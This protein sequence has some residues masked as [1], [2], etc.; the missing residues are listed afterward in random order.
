MKLFT[1]DIETVIA[2]DIADARAVWHE[3]NGG[4]I[5]DFDD[6]DAENPWREMADNETL[7]I[8]CDE[9]GDPTDEG[10]YETVEKTAAEW[11]KRGRGYLCIDV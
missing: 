10:C 8:C 3:Q 11:A 9:N 1:N 6:N 4:D 5:E 2:L 7:R